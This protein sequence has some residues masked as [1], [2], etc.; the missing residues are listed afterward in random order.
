MTRQGT[1]RLWI[2]ASLA[3]SSASLCLLTYIWPSW[4]EAVLHLD[5]DGGSGAVEWL[6]VAGLLTATATFAL[7]ARTEWLRLARKVG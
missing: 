2:E 1:L 6:V 5:P 3:T 4:L 7:R